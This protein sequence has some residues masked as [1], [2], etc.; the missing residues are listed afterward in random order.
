M[1]DR[2]KQVIVKHTAIAEFERRWQRIAEVMEADGVNVRNPTNPQTY[3]FSAVMHALID[4]K[5]ENID[6]DNATD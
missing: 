4:E 3:S 2:R 5:Y 6:H 1:T